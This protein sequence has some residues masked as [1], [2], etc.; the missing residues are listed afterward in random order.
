MWRAAVAE[1]AAV[2]PLFLLLLLH[3]IQTRP[4]GMEEAV[5]EALE[6]QVPALPLKGG[7]VGVESD[8]V[9]PGWFAL[10]GGKGAPSACAH[11]FLLACSALAS[12][13][14][15]RGGVEEK[16]WV[17]FGTC[18]PPQ[19][20]QPL[21]QQMLRAQSRLDQV[22]HLGALTLQPHTLE[23]MGAWLQDHSLAVGVAGEGEVMAMLG[24]L[25]VALTADANPIRT[26]ALRCV[27]LLAPAECV[28]GVVEGVAEAHAE[29]AAD[30]TYLHQLIISRSTRSFLHP[31]IRAS[32]ASSL[33]AGAVR[34]CAGLR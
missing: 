32:M 5:V 23:A 8:G 19:A 16:V 34:G 28:R 22:A 25:L 14:V 15:G 20:A 21:L 31:S 2:Q 17:L 11:L 30:K 4:A 3:L 29:L 27:T 26:A 13:V 1:D 33:M 6:E 7:V 24:L 12:W 9:P 10:V 18:L